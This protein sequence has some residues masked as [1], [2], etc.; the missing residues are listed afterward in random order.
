MYGPFSFVAKKSIISLSRISGISG[1]D[2]CSDRNAFGLGF[3]SFFVEGQIRIFA[4]Q[5]LFFGKL[6]EQE[7]RKKKGL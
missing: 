1:Y 6:L 4:I 5:I 2:I 3:R 7:K